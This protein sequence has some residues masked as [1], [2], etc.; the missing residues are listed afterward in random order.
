MRRGRDPEGALSKTLRGDAHRLSVKRGGGIR[1]EDLQ[2]LEVV[3]LDGGQLP[4]IELEQISNDDR[5]QLQAD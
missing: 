5:L 3:C 1:A 2:S 4:R